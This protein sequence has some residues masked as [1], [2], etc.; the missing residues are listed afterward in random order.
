MVPP[1][2]L[3]GLLALLLVQGTPGHPLLPP[4][5]LPPW[6][7]GGLGA[8]V[9]LPRH[10]LGVYTNLVRLC[11]VMEWLEEATTGWI[12]GL[13]REEGREE[14]EE[15]RREEGSHG[16]EEHEEERREEAQRKKEE[17][18]GDLKMEHRMSSHHPI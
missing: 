1:L 5:L 6:V 12:P 10:M 14:H 7:A 17:D 2:Q 4:G 16:R 9:D 18:P 11:E 3:S 15:G 8:V 13:G